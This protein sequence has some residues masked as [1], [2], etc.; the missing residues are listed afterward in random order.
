MRRT[1]RSMLLAVLLSA[2]MLTPFGPVQAGYWGDA[3]AIA[4]ATR[5]ASGDFQTGVLTPCDLTI[6]ADPTKFDSVACTGVVVDSADPTNPVSTNVDIAAR[7]AVA[8]AFPASDTTWLLIDDTDTLSQ[9]NAAPSALERRDKI[10]IGSLVKAGGVIILTV[11]NQIPAYGLLKTFEDQL[12]ML[13]GMASGAAIGTSD[14]DLSLDVTAGEIIS[15]GRGIPFDVTKPNTTL[16]PA[17]TPFPVGKLFRSYENVSGVV[18]ID[19]T[20]NQIDPNNFASAGVLTAVSAGKYTIQRGILFPATDVL[21]LYYGNT[22]FDTLAEAASQIETEDWSEHPDT[23]AGAFRAWIIVQEGTT[24]LLAACQAVPAKAAII[25]SGPL[26]PGIADSAQLPTG[27]IVAQVTDSTSQKPGVTTPVVIT[28][29]TDDLLQGIG[30]DRPED[31]RA[32]TARSLHFTIQYQVER[33]GS[34][35]IVEWHAWIRQGRRDGDVTAVSVANPTVITSKEHRITTGQTMTIAGCT[36]SASVN[37]ANV[38]TVID[39]NSF[40]IPVNVTSVTDGTCTWTRSLDV[41]DDVA[42]S[43]IKRH[44]IS[45]N[46][47]SPTTS[48]FNLEVEEE[49]V[50]NF[51]QSIDTLGKGAG[52][53]AETIAGEPAIP[54][55][56]VSITVAGTQ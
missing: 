28:F 47:A 3:A 54:S 24:D 37:G 44:L 9:V 25:I 43:N 5:L 32:L 7:T 48:S 14:N 1:M 8:D 40:S 33:T 56:H 27:Q 26:R 53:L 35:G 11:D 36:T 30:R 38:A 10:V 41:T 2:L 42:N 18:V 21:A 50:I 31:F 17:Q 12:M 4:E 39:A 20:S 52:L 55:A 46:E 29:D 15:L 34:G 45:T 19:P 23:M 6:N 49:D 16:T 13:G 51:F 22:E